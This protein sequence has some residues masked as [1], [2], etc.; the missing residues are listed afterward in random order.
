MA[1]SALTWLSIIHRC[2][3]VTTGFAP[4][5]IYR[6][7]GLRGGRAQKRLQ[8]FSALVGASNQTSR[9]SKTTGTVEFPGSSSGKARESKV[10]RERGWSSRFREAPVAKGPIPL[11][12]H[13]CL[14][15]PSPRRGLLSFVAARPSS[16]ASPLPTSATGS[17]FAAAGEV[18]CRSILYVPSVGPM[19]K[20]DIINPK[21]KNTTLCQNSFP[22]YLSFIKGVVDSNYLPLNVSRE[23][24]QESC[25]IRIMKKHLVRKAFEM[26]QG[27]AM[28]G[29]RDDYDKFRENFGKHIN[30][31]C[32]G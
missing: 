14:R 30:L 24:L 13:Y 25:I 19:G 18:E 5:C 29:N 4:Y 7:I 31:G 11:T 22:R 23:R 20:E 1:T 3:V 21:T 2:S 32:L 26:I 15:P 28:G 10:E 8:L 12:C 17:G 9:Y 27:I 6:W 16:L